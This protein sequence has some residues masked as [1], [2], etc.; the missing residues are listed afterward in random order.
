MCLQKSLLMTIRILFD[1]E[2]VFCRRTLKPETLKDNARV[3]GVDGGQVDHAVPS[4]LVTSLS[5]MFSSVPLIFLS[6]TSPST[7][8]PTI[9]WYT[10]TP[11]MDPRNGAKIGTKNQQSPA[12]LHTKGMTRKILRNIAAGWSMM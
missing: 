8:H 12:L 9:S 2:K 5:L 4:L 10:I 1:E 7:C 11:M 3:G 6:R